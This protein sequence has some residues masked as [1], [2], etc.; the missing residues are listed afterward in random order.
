MIKEECILVNYYEVYENDK[1]LCSGD[2]NS[3]ADAL[4]IS[5]YA[6]Y[7]FVFQNRDAKYP[8][9]RIVENKPKRVRRKPTNHYIVYLKGND[10]PIASG[11]AETCAK[12]LGRSIH[13]FYSLVTRVRNGENEKYII[14]IKSP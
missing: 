7:S 5:R 6:F 1:L 11:D 10:D 4:G 9:Y 14:D 2:A 8:K 12:E 3:C 13:S